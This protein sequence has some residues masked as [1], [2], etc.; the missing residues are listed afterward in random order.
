MKTFLEW[1]KPGIKVKRYVLLQI[2]SVVMLAYTT[3]K[4]FGEEVQGQERILAYIALM[5][6]SLFLTVYSFMLAQRN[7]LKVTILTS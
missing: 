1:L 3:F 4:C 5:T 7:I 2:I 6:I